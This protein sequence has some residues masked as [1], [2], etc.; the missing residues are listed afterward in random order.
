[1]KRG[2][3]RAR[4]CVTGAGGRLG[5]YV[6][7]ALRSDYAL[8]LADRSP[9]PGDDRFIRVDLLKD[10]LSRALAG[11]DIVVH[12]A[13]ID[14]SVD[15]SDADVFR[16]NILSTWNVFEAAVTNGIKRTILC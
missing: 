14:G 7:E 2:T 9:P 16:I 12:L 3:K 15:A 10:Q 13:A 11:A 5:R 8:T 6:I 4:I 1:M